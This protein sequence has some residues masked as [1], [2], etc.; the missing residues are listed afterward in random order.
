MIHSL[1]V[2]AHVTSAMILVAAFGIEGLILLQLRQAQSL[3]DARPVLK[4]FRYVPRAG[5]AGLGATVVTGIYLATAYWSWQGAWMGGAPR[6]APS[7]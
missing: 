1:I 4:K 6:S 7:S 3:A 2:F 5:G